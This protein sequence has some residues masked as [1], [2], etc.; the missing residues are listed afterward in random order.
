MPSEEAEQRYPLLTDVS[1]YNSHGAFYP[2][3]VQ[4]MAVSMIETHLA[5]RKIGASQLMN[6]FGISWVLVSFSAEICRPMQ[7]DARF[8]GQT[9]HTYTRMPVFRREFII[10]DE[11]G[12]VVIGA[13][14]ST[15]VDIETRKICTDRTL[16]HRFDAPSGE[17][18]LHATHRAPI[19]HAGVEAGRR[20]V[21]P[22]WL[23][24]VGH[25]NNL[26]YAEMA[27]DTLTPE[28]R[29]RIEF[30]R[31]FDIWFQHELSE[32]G[33][34]RMRKSVA[35]DSFIICGMI[36]AAQPAFTARMLLC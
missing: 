27:Y 20:A 19:V 4:R 10:S 21:Q 14:H 15:L 30:F 11:K 22:S 2:V 17:T 24:G 32:D 7:P 25:V 3:S 13:T 31:R 1:M 6:D 35:A 5:S 9:W 8:V 12:P 28:E 33:F 26:R 36:P 16:L 18:L 23:D 29:R 34:C